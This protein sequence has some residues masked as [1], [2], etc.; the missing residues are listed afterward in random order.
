MNKALR[1]AVIDLPFVEFHDL[2]E[3]YPDMLINVKHEQ[4]LAKDA[5]LLVF[6]HPFYWYSSPAIIKQWYDMVLERG[7][8]Y[9]EKGDSLKGKN[10]MLAITTGGPA[11][12]YSKDGYNKFTIEQFLVPQLQTANLCGM[13]FI[14]PF[15][16]HSSMSANS[17]E[18][19]KQSLRYR[20]LLTNL[21]K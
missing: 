16:V 7:W 3:S 19:T 21:I 14:T 18:I 17:E 15:I 10:M 6:Q 12:S 8:A 20:D 4:T 9:G 1:N 5:D 11:S 13:N 2:Y